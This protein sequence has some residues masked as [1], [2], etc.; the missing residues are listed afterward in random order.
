MIWTVCFTVCMLVYLICLAPNYA[1]L[2]TLFGSRKQSKKYS[3][4]LSLIFNPIVLIVI[5]FGIYVIKSTN[6]RLVV[7]YKEDAPKPPLIKV[8]LIIDFFYTAS[9]VFTGA[10]F[11]VDLAFTSLK[12]YVRY[13]RPNSS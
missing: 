12:V 13:S 10:Y 9:V 2:F 5:G 8:L 7:D 4:K 6:K 11:I 3:R 1:I